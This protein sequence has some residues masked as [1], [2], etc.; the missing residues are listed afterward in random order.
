MQITVKIKLEPTREQFNL[1]LATTKEYILL[2][3]RIVAEF[4]EADAILKYMSKSVVA[5]LSSAVKNRAIRD[6]K[7]V[8]KKYK[9][10]PV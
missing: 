9:K 5:E 8:F 3:K 4:V 6:A 10:R 1:L 7:S 2:V